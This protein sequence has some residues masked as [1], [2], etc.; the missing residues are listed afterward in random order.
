MAVSIAQTANP[1]GV[2]AVTRVAT[3]TNAAIGT[4]D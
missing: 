1:A 3:Y 4:A 2:T